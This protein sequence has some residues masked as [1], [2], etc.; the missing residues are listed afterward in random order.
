MPAE[1]ATTATADCHLWASRGR[2]GSS[3]S[4]SSSSTTHIPGGADVEA[5][6]GHHDPP[7]ETG[8]VALDEA[9]L[10]RREGHGE[11]G[12]Q[13]RAA[14]RA[15]VPVDARGDVDGQHPHPVGHRRRLVGPLESGAVGGVDHEVDR[16]RRTDVPG[17]LGGV[18]H[19][20]PRAAAR[21]GERQP[22]GRPHRCC[23]CPPRPRPGARRR[24]RAAAGRGWPR[25]C[26]RAPPGPA[27]R[28]ARAP[29]RRRRASAPTLTTGLMPL[30]RPAW[31]PLPRP[32]RW[33]RPPR[34]VWVSDT[35]QRRTPRSVGERGGA[36]RQRK[37]GAPVLA[38]HDLHLLHRRR[39]DAHAERLQHRLLGG[40]AGREARRRGHGRPPRSR[41]RMA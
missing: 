24:R 38:P 36:P 22:R 31:R 16:A 13:G 15:G 6:V 10:E 27:R 32:P 37:Q 41:A 39:P 40:E 35:C 19:G 9:R 3:R 4:T 12:A 25:P 28:R 17:C 23:P 26:R 20:D 2:R 29:G 21:A 18:E 11:V 8:T 30:P 7:G 34:S 5:D 33:P 14:G 1:P